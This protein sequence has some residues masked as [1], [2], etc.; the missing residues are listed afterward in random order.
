MALLLQATNLFASTVNDRYEGVG[1]PIVLGLGV[2]HLV[3]AGFVLRYRGPLTRGRAWTAAWVAMIFTV[4]MLLAHLLAPGDFAAYGVGVPMGNYALIPLAVFAFYPWGGFRD[5]TKRRLIEGAL[6]ISIVL[7]PLLI[8]ELMTRG[9][10]TGLHLLSIGQYGVWAIVWF[11]VG[12]GLAWLCRIAVE[13]ETEALSQSYETTLGDLH[14]HLEAAA[15]QIE[16]GRDVRE[17]AQQFRELTAT[18]RRQLL[19]TEENV[20][21]VDLFKNAVRAHGDRLT[22]RATP[23]LGGLTVPRA[24]AILLEQGL[25]DLLKNAVDHGGGIVEIGFAVEGATMTLDVRDFGPGLPPE[26]FAEPGGKLEHL[27][28]R[29]RDEGGDL[30]LLP[31]GAGGGTLVRLTLPLRPIR[32]PR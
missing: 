4:Q 21:A 25:A 19:L 18:R 7:H 28:A 17:L 5:A 11:L 32:V 20:G 15:Q 22:L 31:S 1:I 8:V 9:V 14:T 2:G 12:K 26:R 29:L 6:I 23:H 24:Q 30:S 13:V 3:L 16:T 27:R 10:P